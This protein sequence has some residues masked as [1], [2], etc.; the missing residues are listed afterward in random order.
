MARKRRAKKRVVKK[1]KWRNFAPSSA[2]YKR[3]CV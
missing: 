1:R 3:P 2:V